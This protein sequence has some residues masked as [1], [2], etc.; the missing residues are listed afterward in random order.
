M[1][2][3]ISFGGLSSGLD[4]SAIIQA[5]VSVER[6]PINMLETRKATEQRKISSVGTLSGLVDGLREK[7]SKLATLGD[8]MSFTTS[9]SNESLIDV[10]AN[11]SAA[12]GSHSIVVQQVLATDRWAFDGVLDPTTDLATSGGTNISYDYEG[13][14]YAFTF[15]SS[16]GT[17][18][19]DIAAAIN[20]GPNGGVT[21]AV[22]QTG[23]ANAPDGYQLV[24]TAAD[25]GETRKIANINTTVEGLTINS[26][27]GGA[28]NITQGADAIAV[29]D[30]LRFQRESNDFSDVLAGVSLQVL[31]ADINETVTFTVGADKDSIKTK[32]K[33]FT[34][35]Y[36]EV[37]TFINDQSSYSEDDGAGGLLFGD[38]I[39]RTVQRSMYNTIFGQVSAGSNP[40]GFDTLGII[41]IEVDNLGMLSIDDTT[42]DAKM[43][44]DLDA[45][46]DLFADTD[47][48]D[49]GGAVKGDPNYYV[50]ITADTGLADDLMREID[51]LTKGFVGPGGS[52]LKGIF[53]TRTEALEG[54]V[55]RIDDDIEAK[56]F[57]LLRF[58]DNLIARY[59]ALES[60]MASINAQGSSLTSF[61]SA[62]S[63]NN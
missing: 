54:I 45:V 60:V 8:F 35:A 15:T 2:G 26:T 13:T 55:T 12:A 33:E 4:T 24:I 18:L 11:S 56:E 5:L 14:N 3:G 63:N 44:E 16:V 46:A 40:G 31:A 58:E 17:S 38:N 23:T 37:M 39:L 30:G 34:E 41:G 27:P 36:N 9:S 6:I 62:Q 53:D 32:I 29:I 49:N 20:N 10:S 28:S 43:D 52:L 21:A 48:F 47:G 25:G 57:R 7:A 51:R 19:D 61:F 50:D 1:F 59:A 22:V 42:L